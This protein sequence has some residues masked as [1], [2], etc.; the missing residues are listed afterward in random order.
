LCPPAVEDI[1]DSLSLDIR[2]CIKFSEYS[3]ENIKVGKL[4]KTRS[5]VE[6]FPTL[7]QKRVGINVR[8]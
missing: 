4:E 6:V 2:K 7:P 3:F 1:M 5:L 8:I